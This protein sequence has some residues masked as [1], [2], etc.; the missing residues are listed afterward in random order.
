[1]L[2]LNGAPPAGGLTPAPSSVLAQDSWDKVIVFRL[3]TGVISSEHSVEPLQI[4]ATRDGN[5][6]HLTQ[7]ID[8]AVFG[9][10][11]ITPDGVIG[12][13]EAEQTGTFLPPDLDGSKP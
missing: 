1:V 3:H 5:S 9:S 11:I 13:V 10:P 7:P 6:I 2:T 8:D 4:G 12:I